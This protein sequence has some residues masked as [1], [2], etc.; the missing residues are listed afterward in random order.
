MCVFGS[1]KPNTEMPVKMLAQKNGRPKGRTAYSAAT[2][3]IIEQAFRSGLGYRRILKNYPGHGMTAEGV[4]AV[5][6]KLK[7]MGSIDR[8][9]GSGR[10]VASAFRGGRGGGLRGRAL[11]PIGHAAF[12]AFF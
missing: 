7:Q 12:P 9:K 3:A 6:K 10:S 1:P 5:T 8:T 11:P 2:L 4:K